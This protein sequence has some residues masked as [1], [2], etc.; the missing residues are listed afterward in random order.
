MTGKGQGVKQFG[1]LPVGGF[2]FNYVFDPMELAV[3]HVCD[4][5]YRVVC[6]LLGYRLWL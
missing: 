2:W 3:V 5:L 4:R 6:W 1:Y